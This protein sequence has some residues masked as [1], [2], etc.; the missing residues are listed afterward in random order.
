MHV[1]F[2]LI[3]M[4][5]NHKWEVHGQILVALSAA[6]DAGA[7]TPLLDEKRLGLEKVGDAHTRLT[8]G[9]AIGKVAVDV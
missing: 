1:V 3:P 7:L 2:M 5:H 8:S 4:L 6:V 9:E